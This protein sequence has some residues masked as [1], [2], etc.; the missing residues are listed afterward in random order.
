MEF[1][2]L[3]SESYFNR[4]KFSYSIEKKNT[5]ITVFLVMFI[6]LTNSFCFSSAVMF[7][8]LQDIIKLVNATPKAPIETIVCTQSLIRIFF[9]ASFISPPIFCLLYLFIFL[10]KIYKHRSHRSY[11]F[12]SFLTFLYCIF[13]IFLPTFSTSDSP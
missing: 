11:I 3:L 4:L 6:V 10:S 13:Y 8:M 12:H 9:S 2:F 7:F 1:V 5:F